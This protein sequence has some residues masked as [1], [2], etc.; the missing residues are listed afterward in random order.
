MPSVRVKAKGRLCNR[1]VIDKRTFNET[2]SINILRYL[3]FSKT[4]YIIPKDRKRVRE[5]EREWQQKAWVGPI[6]SREP[7][8]FSK[9]PRSVQEPQLFLTFSYT[10]VLMLI[11]LEGFIWNATFDYVLSFLIQKQRETRLGGCIQRLF[12]Q[13]ILLN[14]KIARVYSSSNRMWLRSFA[15]EIQRSKKTAHLLFS[16]TSFYTFKFPFMF[17]FFCF[18]PP[19]PPWLSYWLSLPLDVSQEEGVWEF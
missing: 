11:N 10:F 12:I 2:P 4:L 16:F 7:G 14:I 17:F 5:R 3:L 1:S 9:S 8:R 18:L 13:C 6:Q 15:V 19:N